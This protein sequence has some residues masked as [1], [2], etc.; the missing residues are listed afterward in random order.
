MDFKIYCGLEENGKIAGLESWQ[1]CVYPEFTERAGRKCRRLIINQPDK[2]IYFRTLCDIPKGLAAAVKI[3]YFD[4]GTGHFALLY[5]SGGEKRYSEP[6]LLGNTMQW[7]EYVFYLY[8]V[9]FDKSLCASDFCIDL[10]PKIYGCSAEHIIFGSA[11]VEFYEAAPVKINITSN[12]AAGNTF[13]ETEEVLLFAETENTSDSAFSAEMKISVL[14]DNENIVMNM[15]KTAELAAHGK[16]MTELKI[17]V[18]GFGI[19]ILKLEFICAGGR[20]ICRT[21]FAYSMRAQKNGRLGGCV[22]F[23]ERDSA[24]VAPLMS[25]CGFGYIRDGFLWKDYETQKGAFVFRPE[26]ERYLGDAEK[27]GLDMLTLLGFNNPLYHSGAPC[28]P[29]TSEEI[30]AFGKYIHTLVSFLGSRC[31]MY[32]IWNE[33]NLASFSEDISPEAYIRVLKAA[34]PAVKSANPDAYII[35]PGTCGEA[36]PWVERFLRLGGGEYLDALSIHPYI[37]TPG[38]V[39]GGLFKKLSDTEALIQKYCPKLKLVVSELGWSVQSGGV[40]RKS[41]AEYFVK[42][43]AIAQ[44]FKILEK[45]FMYEFQDSG[46]SVSDVERNFG[47]VEYWEAPTPYAAK[48]AYTAAAAFN[49]LIGGKT[50]DMLCGADNPD[51]ITMLR[52]KADDGFT[53]M[54]WSERREYILSAPENANIYDINGNAADNDTVIGVSPVYVQT[55]F[56]TEDITAFI[57]RKGEGK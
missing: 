17:P 35:G 21:R 39:D 52:F 30:S 19:Y 24:A 11:E 25:A 51:A 56:N 55:G 47:F 12:G 37:W 44:S 22:H 2:R 23:T 33:P 57:R 15:Q 31:G 41:H 8:G 26:W 16:S 48:P 27:A 5:K 32:E 43:L 45:Y 53:F 3:S 6:V 10:A 9:D 49:K 40:T 36:L 54:V 13:F 1:S 50:P 34:A 7:K 46:I 18:T 20:K 28:V 42:S 14:D 29:K 4:E 38:P